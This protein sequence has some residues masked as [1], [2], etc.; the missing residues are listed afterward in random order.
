MVSSWTSTFSY[1]GKSSEH[2]WDTVFTIQHFSP[3]S[4]GCSV[5]ESVRWPVPAIFQGGLLHVR[6]QIIHLP[7]QCYVIYSALCSQHFPYLRRSWIQK[8]Q[9]YTM[10]WYEIWDFCPPNCMPGSSWS[11]ASKVWLLLADQW[12][13]SIQIRSLSQPNQLNLKTQNGRCKQLQRR[14]FCN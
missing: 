4:P 11:Q 2:T 6:I 7:V 13:H 1:S 12:L 9:W 5:R 8:C 14:C 3:P 10:A